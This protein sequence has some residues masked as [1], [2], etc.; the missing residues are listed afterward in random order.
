ME[1]LSQ[2]ILQAQ[3]RLRQTTTKKKV[4]DDLTNEKVFQAHANILVE[5]A[6]QRLR[7]ENRSFVIDENNAKVM[8]LLLYY[9]N[10]CPLFETFFEDKKYK[11][12]NNLML[13]G[14]VGVGK[15]MTL[16]IFSDYLRLTGNPNHFFN[17]SVTQMINYYKLHNHLD[18]YTYNEENSK[19]FD[20]DPFNICLND[21]GMQ[22]HVHFGTDTKTIVCDFFHARNEIWA[23]Q[24][25]KTH[26][27]TNLSVKDMKVYFQDEYG[28]LVDR[29]KTYNV[30]HLKGV[31]R[32]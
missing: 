12:S 2:I 1:A 21:V 7:N 9:F 5:C 31:S 27:T 17:L 4:F 14:E 32:R 20:G 23:M 6:N 15:T 13:C 18:K 24:S 16:Q 11:L 29:F 28:R 30:I 25:K 26:I 19:N 3:Q 22:T 8:R 10:Q